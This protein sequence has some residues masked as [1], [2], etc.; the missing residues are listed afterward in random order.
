MKKNAII[1]ILLI[2][3]FIICSAESAPNGT[4]QPHSN[5]TPIVSVNVSGANST[6]TP[7]VGNV[8][9]NASHRINDGAS[10]Q[11]NSADQ[12]FLFLMNQYWIPDFYDIKGRMD[13]A[14]TF[15]TDLPQMLN[16]TADYARI[17]L[18][19]KYHWGNWYFRTRYS[20]TDPTYLYVPRE[21][22]P[23]GSRPYIRY[24]VEK[25]TYQMEDQWSWSQYCWY[26]QRGIRGFSKYRGSCR[27]SGCGSYD[28]TKS[29][30][31]ICRRER[32]TVP[33]N[34][35]YYLF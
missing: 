10:I 8:S 28:L 15:G 22:R 32:K 27:I 34:F 18:I 7:V 25:I 33:G 21:G 5:S 14:A 19:R 16:L 9:N 3:S 23:S 29:R 24:S 26:H 1:F 20:G 11:T 13:G 2:I 12:Q 35:R 30:R 4:P 31:K 17:R 6:A